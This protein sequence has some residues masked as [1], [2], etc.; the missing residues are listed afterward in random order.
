MGW[1]CGD[2]AGDVAVGEGKEGDGKEQEPLGARAAQGAP[3][4]TNW[5]GRETFRVR[6]LLV[7]LLMVKRRG[8][9][10]VNTGEGP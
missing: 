9:V 3:T 5:R 1:L 4:R 2:G 10:W 8:G 6:V 7:R